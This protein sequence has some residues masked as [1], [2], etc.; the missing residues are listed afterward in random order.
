MSTEKFGDR[1]RKIARGNYKDLARRADIL[2]SSKGGIETCHRR[3]D[4]AGAG[5]RSVRPVAGDGGRDER[6]A[7]VRRG[8][9]GISSGARSIHKSPGRCAYIRDFW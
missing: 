6:D 5:G 1:L 3:G 7:C 8:L 4:C 2:P 9:H